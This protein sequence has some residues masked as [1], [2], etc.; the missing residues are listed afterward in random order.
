MLVAALMLAGCAVVPDERGYGYGG[1][2]RY[3]ERET[4]IVA[5]ARHI[6]HRGPPPGPGHVWIGGYWNRIGPRQ[7]WVPGY[8]APPARHP[9]P[10]MRPWQ[11]ERERGERERGERQRGERQRDA[12]ERETPR[13]R[14]LAPVQRHDDRPRANVR[15]EPHEHLSRPGE[16]RPRAFGER[17]QPPPA[18]VAGER[19]TPTRRPP[20]EAGE[21]RDGTGEAGSG[22]GHLRR[23]DRP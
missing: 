3:Y 2:G 18:A 22:R 20:R 9:H 10:P 12:R 13:P 15:G 5:P 4:V 21:R 7:A 6:E 17:R 16:T 19:G 11:A 8:W 14:P 23:S 1:H